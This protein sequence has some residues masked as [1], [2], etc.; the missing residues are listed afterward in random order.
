MKTLL[1]YTLLGTIINQIYGRRCPAGRG[2]SVSRR[3]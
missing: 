2:T 1:A 3:Y